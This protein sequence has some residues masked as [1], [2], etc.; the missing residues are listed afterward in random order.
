[1]VLGAYS[2]Q[3]REGLQW[4]LPWRRRHLRIFLEAPSAQH[5][6]C[7]E[8]ELCVWRGG[9]A[10]PVGAPA[11]LSPPRLGASVSRLAARAADRPCES[12]TSPVPRPRGL[13]VQQKFLVIPPHDAPSSPPSSKSRLS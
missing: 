4:R 1:M 5:S 6:H 8:S 10:E 3:R 9:A 2:L 12:Q 13:P 11:P 7:F